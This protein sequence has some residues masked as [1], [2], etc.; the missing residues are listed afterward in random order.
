MDVRQL[1]R[2]TR[3]TRIVG[4]D[5]DAKVTTDGRAVPR[6]APRSVGAGL[7]GPRGIIR[8]IGVVTG[9]RRGVSAGGADGGGAPSQRV[10]A[11]R[12]GGAVLAQR[13][14][15]VIGVVA[16]GEVARCGAGGGVDRRDAGLASQCVVLVVAAGTVG[17][18]LD[19]VGVVVRPLV[20]EVTGRGAVRCGTGDARGALESVTT[21]IE[22]VGG[23]PPARVTSTYAKPREAYP[24]AAPRRG[25]RS[26]GLGDDGEATRR[27]V[28]V[29]APCRNARAEPR[30]S[31]H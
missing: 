27:G 30:E 12:G 11:E 31:F 5:D 4:G 25:P 22:V 17:A 16:D 18:G 28:A 1:D 3:P 2:D 13:R 20:D 21:D 15:E 9:D 8:R 19:T 29:M 6:A 23:L 26:A 7:V 10:D 14:R 24:R